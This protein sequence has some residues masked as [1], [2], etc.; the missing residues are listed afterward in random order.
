MRTPLLMIVFGLAL[1]GGANAATMTAAQALAPVTVSPIAAEPLFTGI[2]QNGQTVTL[3]MGQE[4]AVALPDNPTS[5]FQWR[6][7]DLDQGVLV[8]DGDPQVRAAPGAS[9]PVGP[10][11]SV[12]TFATIGPGATTVT[13]SSVHPWDPAGAPD[14]QFTLNVVVR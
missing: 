13:L 10:D 2:E 14:Q 3:S 4:L 7:G 9:G 1:T 5:G 11:T 6:L 8:L 12:W